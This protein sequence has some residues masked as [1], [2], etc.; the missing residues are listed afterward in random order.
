MIKIVK[1]PLQLEPFLNE[2]KDIFTKP[3]YGS[4]RDLCGALSVCDKSKTVANLCD[5]MAE[6]SK[7][8]KARSSYNWFLSDANWD[9][10]EVAQRK[11]DLFIEHLCLKENDKILLIIDDTFNE[12]EGTQTEGV[13]KF[14]DHSK[15]TYIWGNNFVTSVIQAKGLFIPHKAKMYI[16]DNDENE[17]FR[18]KM[19]IA[20]EEIIEPLKVPK[21]IDLYIVF[22]SW[23]FSSDLFSKC[24]SLEHNIVCQIKSDKK[25][26]INKDMYFKV[27]ELANQIEDKYFIKTTISVR[28]RKKTYYT[29]EKKVIIDKVGEVKL[30]VSKR[31][32][33]STTRY[34][35]STNES[36]SSKEVLSIY[37]D[38]WDIETAHRETNQKLGFKDYQLR[39]KQSIK[40]FI[41]LVFSVWAAILFWEMDNPPSEDGSNPRT[42]G[43]MIDRVKM[44]AVGETFEYVMRYFNLPVP[45][46]GLLYILKSLG[47]KI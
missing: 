41:Q 25:I 10:N 3:S 22:D 24:L 13:G 19:E 12:K 8:K 40:R 28:G 47:M 4:F 32:K 6:C 46:G 17:N 31:K 15:E 26:G 44:Q 43:D 33:D 11:V 42:M 16:K 23:W 30:V 29:F 20:F 34:F 7:R 45:D 27:R 38:R 1:A 39:D 21:N 36:L 14:Y 18:T 37:E 2:F 9:E 5:T 35:I